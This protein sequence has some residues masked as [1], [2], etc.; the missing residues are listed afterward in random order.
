MPNSL[1]R[2]GDV[3]PYFTLTSDADE[4]ITL[5]QYRGVANVVLYFYP[6]SDTPGCTLEACNFR[7]NYTALI[8]AGSVILGVSPDPV[9]KQAKFVEKHAL[10]FPILADPDHSVAE[11][12]GLWKEKS[13]MG[14]KYMG[15]ERTTFIID[16]EGVVREVFE[17]VKVAGHSEEVLAALKSL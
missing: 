15:V 6:K 3:S 5:S 4:A 7:D 17:K 16:K 10:P 9:K 12:Y 13:F 1:P 8:E 11:C 14:R 2:V